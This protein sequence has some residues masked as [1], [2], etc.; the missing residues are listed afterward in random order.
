MKKKLIRGIILEIVSFLA[1]LIPMVILTII[2][3]DKWFIHGADKISIGFIIA[4]IF[5]ILLL[6]GAFK[7]VDNRLTTLGT[8]FVLLILVWCF[9]T[10]MD[11]LFW[12]ILCSIFGYAAYLLVNLFARKDLLYVKEYKSEKARMDARLD[13]KKEAEKETEDKPVERERMGW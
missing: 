2:N 12:V 9:Q 8:L 11:D 10:I 13:A 1:L 4:L 5:A 7:N 6:K 3:K